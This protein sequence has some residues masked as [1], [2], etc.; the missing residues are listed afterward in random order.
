MKELEY[1]VEPEA[2]HALINDTQNSSLCI[3]D[4]GSQASYL[5]GHIPG[6]VHLP[7]QALLIGQAPTPGKIAT[8]AQLEEVFSYLG[9]EKDTHFVVYDDEGGGWA[10]RFIWT[11]DVIGHQKYSYLNGGIHA[12][13]NQGFALET[14]S[15][16]RL[17][18]PVTLTLNES[19]IAEM[20][21]VV[22]NIS[23]NHAT[24]W[25]ARSPEEYR[26]QKG[27]AA[28]LGHIPGAINIE[29]TALMDFDNGY[30]IRSDA[31][32]FLAAHGIDGSKPIITHCQSHHRSGFTY[33][34]GKVLGFSIRGYHGSW[35][36]WGNHPETPVER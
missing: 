24:I 4:L 1:L 27:N 19:P 11:L 36:E 23:T 6:A 29:W 32:E 34:V 15:N 16:Q 30:K 8:L 21:D 25:D 9:L 35:A 14:H 10:G 3:V 13:R 20:T 5:E 7:A 28:R 12:W 31:R 18:A 26:G 33:L 17:R 2:L 22:N